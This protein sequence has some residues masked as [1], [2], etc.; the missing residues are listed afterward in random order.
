MK[1]KY[2]ATKIFLSLKKVAENLTNHKIK[3]FQADWGGEYK[4]LKQV[5][6]TFE[7]NF[8]HPCPHTHNQNGKIKRKHRHI[9]KAALALLA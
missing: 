8:L 1:L 6:E 7:I 9:T 2:E 4:P 3:T 5:L